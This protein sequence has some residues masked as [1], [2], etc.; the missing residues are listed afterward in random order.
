VRTDTLDC[1][2]A[3]RFFLLV[4]TEMGRSVL[5]ALIVMIAVI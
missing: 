1:V 3:N 5:M 2:C 4:M